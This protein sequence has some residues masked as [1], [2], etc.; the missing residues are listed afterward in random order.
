MGTIISFR[1]DVSPGRCRHQQ[2]GK[3]VSPVVIGTSFDFDG[4]AAGIVATA[5]QVDIQHIGGG[6]VGANLLGAVR[7]SDGLSI[8]VGGLHVFDV[9]V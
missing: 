2:T 1:L 4:R 7:P 8:D 5:M 3:C 9:P 6:A